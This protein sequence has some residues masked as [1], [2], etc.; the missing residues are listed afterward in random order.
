MTRAT[1]IAQG[2]HFGEGP[3]WHE[4]RLWFSDFHD[5][6]VKSMDESGVIRTELALYDQRRPPLA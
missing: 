2:V 1:V 3:R 6:A 4:G 5:H